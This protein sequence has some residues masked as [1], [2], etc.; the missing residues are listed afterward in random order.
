MLPRTM[1]LS[2]EPSVEKSARESEPASDAGTP[3]AAAIGYQ[4]VA[5]RYRPQRFDELVGQEHVARGLSGA[6]ESGRIGHA[7]LFTGARGVGKTSA[8]RIYAKALE[9]TSRVRGEPC[10]VCDSCVAIAA[11]QDVDVVE[12]DAEGFVT[13]VG[14]TRRFAKVAGE[15][16]SLD[17]IE[18]V[19]YLASPAYR[20]AALLQLVP[21]QG[22]STVLFTTDGALTRSALL[23]ASR[24]LG[25][26]DLTTA[27]SIVV[28]SVLPLLGNGK[29]DYVTLDQ[30]AM[31]IAAAAIVRA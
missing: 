14:R 10:N 20:H 26:S 15:M 29:T 13:I 18:R 25:A 23:R 6:I 1:S 2:M 9:C 17:A 19:A 11:G 22:E 21:G 27:R 4:V 16:I 12:I 8:A 24:E 31:E 28:L 30:R 3:V 7:Y 5:R